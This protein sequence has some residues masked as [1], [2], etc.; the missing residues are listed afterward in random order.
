MSTAL[1]INIPLM[2]LA[3]GLMAGI[4]LWMVLRRPD[5]HDKH[6]TR[7]V[8]AYLARRPAPVRVAMVRLPRSSG[9]EGHRSMRPLTGDAN[10]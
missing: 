7:T 1:W 10:G 4:P 3:F 8:P 6:E 5:W 9:Y 2:V